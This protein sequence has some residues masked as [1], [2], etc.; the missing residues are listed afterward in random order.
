MI[1]MNLF[2]LYGFIFFI[3]LKSDNTVNLNAVL[4]AFI[5]LFLFFLPLTILMFVSY[6]F[7][8]EKIIIKY[9]LIKAKECNTNNIIGYILENNTDNDTLKIYTSINIFN[10]IIYGKKL[11]NKAYEFMNEYYE[12]IKFR[13]KTELENSGVLIKYNKKK[14]IRLFEEYLELV[15]NENKERYFYA[16]L[17]VKLIN[18]YVIKLI[19]KDNIKIN[20]N[21]YQ[22][23]GRF[24]LFE[25]LQNIYIKKNG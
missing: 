20:F 25:Y 1:F 3:L 21:I 17:K 19:T 24:G 9:P 4:F 10:I 2:C 5:I 12:N 23:R 14:H 16:N 15:I 22:C 6:T 11:R 18:D 7:S 13:N 8:K